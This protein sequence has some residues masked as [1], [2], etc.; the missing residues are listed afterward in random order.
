MTTFS[1]ASILGDQNAKHQEEED[2]DDEEEEDQ[3]SLEEQHQ[4]LLNNSVHHLYSIFCKNAAVA[5]HLN[6]QHQNKSNL[7][8]TF[9]LGTTPSSSNDFYSLHKL[10]PTSY[11]GTDHPM[12][13]YE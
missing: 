4:I 12:I 8:R 13:I 3:N 5:A 9:P 11:Q 6:G 10:N 7:I 1:I 2:D